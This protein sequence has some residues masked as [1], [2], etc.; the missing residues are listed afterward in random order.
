MMNLTSILKFARFY[1][2]YQW[3]VGAHKYQ[4]LF[5]NEYICYQSGQKVLDI[6]CGPADILN[7]L[8][9]NVDYTG[10]DIS[11]N[12]ILKAKQTWPDKTFIQ[13]D[14]ADCEFPVDDNS[15]DT[16]IFIGVQHHVPNEVVAQMLRFAYRKLK[17]GGRMLSLEPVYTEKQGVLERF[18]MGS[19]RGKF[20][21]TADE[22]QMLT[23]QVFSDN[24]YE[25]IRGT[26]NI[27]FTIMITEAEK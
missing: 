14:I 26:M 19:D 8:P 25:I 10:I 15:F 1:Q 5:T 3:L 4:H 24:R 23:N 2:L 18:I 9:T 6:G 17:N 7:I 16:V 22:Y 21:R 13:G 12:Y 11:E 27:P 20:I